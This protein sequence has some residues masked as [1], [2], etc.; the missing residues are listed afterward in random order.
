MSVWLFIH[1]LINH[2]K[3]TVIG[4][5]SGIFWDL[6]LVNAMVADDLA[7]YVISVG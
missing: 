6:E 7:A 5:K 2:V 1:C 4:D 3:N